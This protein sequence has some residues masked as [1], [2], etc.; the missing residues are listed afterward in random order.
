MSAVISLLKMAAVLIAASFLGNLFLSEL[1]KARALKKPW[2]APYLT[3]PGLLIIIALFIPV[4]IW[5]F[6]H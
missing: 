1:K 5:I 3:L 2:Y 6:Q 4:V